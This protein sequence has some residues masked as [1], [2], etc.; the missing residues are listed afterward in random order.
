MGINGR[1]MH[2]LI[3]PDEQE[4]MVYYDGVN[5]HALDNEDE[6]KSIQEVYRQCNDG[7]EIPCFELGSIKAPWAHRFFD[8]I[9][10]GAPKWPHMPFSG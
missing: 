8:A 6:M 1:D 10:H 4:F 5:L 2:C 3:K 7:A 9:A